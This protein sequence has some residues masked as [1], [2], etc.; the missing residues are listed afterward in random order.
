M[1][2]NSQVIRIFSTIS[3]IF[4]QLETSHTMMDCHSI[5]TE[6]PG[7]SGRRAPLSSQEDCPSPAPCP[8]ER[9]PSSPIPDHLPTMIEEAA[10]K[11]V[12]MKKHS[13]LG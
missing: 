10:P 13:L 2:D 8:T 3:F 4:I 11:P 12:Q 6:P 1:N 7:C 9:P 5:A